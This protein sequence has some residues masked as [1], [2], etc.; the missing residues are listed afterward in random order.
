MATLSSLEKRTSGRNLEIFRTR[1]ICVQMYNSLPNDFK[2]LPREG[3]LVAIFYQLKTF[4][5][6]GNA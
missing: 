4:C 5:L 1:F 3:N 6:V 2:D